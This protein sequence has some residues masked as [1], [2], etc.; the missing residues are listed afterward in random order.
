MSLN[1]LDS[2]CLHHFPSPSFFSPSSLFHR[3]RRSPRN[4][5]RGCGVCVTQMNGAAYSCRVGL[6]DLTP[7]HQLASASASAAVAAAG[8]NDN[9][10]NTSSNE[11]CLISLFEIYRGT[12]NSDVW[13]IGHCRIL[14]ASAQYATFCSAS[15]KLKSINYNKKLSC[16]CDSRSYCVRRPV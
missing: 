6:S 3:P 5:Q 2:T 1:D 8:N 7:H 15:V 9:T 11:H 4:L 16:C 14:G 12:R 13:M 10:W